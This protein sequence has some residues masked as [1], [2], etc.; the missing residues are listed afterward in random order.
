MR[1]HILTFLAVIL[2]AA[3]TSSPAVTPSAVVPTAAPTLPAMNCSAVYAAAATPEAALGAEFADRAQIAGRS[4]APVTIVVFSN[5]Q[6][7]ECAFLG[8][9]LAQV[10]TSHPDDVRIVYLHAPRT[11]NDKDT[12]A[13]QAAEAAGLQGMFWEMHNLLF[14]KQPEWSA[15]TPEQFPEWAAGQAAALGMDAAVFRS[16]FAG[17]VVAGKV[18][19]ALQFAES[20]PTLT[21]PTFFVNSNTPYTGLADFASLDEVVRLYALSARQFSACPPWEID[22]LKQYVATLETGQGDIVIELYPDKAPQAV[23]NFVFL[24]RQGWFDGM[25]FYRVL[26]GSLVQ[27][28]DPSGTGKGMPGYLFETEIP[29]GLGFSEAGMVAMEN[30]GPDTNGSRFFITLTALPELDGSYTIFGRVLSGMDV[31]AA[32][33]PRDAQPGSY[34]PPGDIIVHITIEER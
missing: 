5:Y 18:Q 31:L 3:C 4:D 2:L 8:V 27:T 24:A 1:R 21:I 34:L 10:R 26:P 15:L 16:D 25:T 20:V 22:P 32:L 23:N 12:L 13:I 28:G 11:E 19:A 6:C 30:N 14:Q 9:S 29:A 33:T 7:L 17:D